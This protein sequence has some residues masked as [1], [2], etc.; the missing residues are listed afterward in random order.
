MDGPHVLVGFDAGTGRGRPRTR[1]HGGRLASDARGLM[2]AKVARTASEDFR[3]R[4]RVGDW[5]SGIAR[6]LRSVTV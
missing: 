4:D 6:D 2:A 1:P 5:A 3:D